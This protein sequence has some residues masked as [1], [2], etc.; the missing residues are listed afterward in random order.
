MLD[1]VMAAVVAALEPAGVRCFRAF[2]ETEKDLSAGAG[3]SLG[4]DS[5]KVLSAGMGDYIGVRAATGGSDETAL[6]GKRVCAVWRKERVLPLHRD[7]GQAQKRAFHS[8]GGAEGIGNGLRR[9][10]NRRGIGDLPL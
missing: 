5:Y 10:K 4:I 6:F 7:D 8:A 9:C 2:P 1:A 3:V